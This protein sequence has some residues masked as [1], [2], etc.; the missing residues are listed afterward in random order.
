MPFAALESC[1]G[2]TILETFKLLVAWVLW[3]SRGDTLGK[4]ATSLL[5]PLLS[6]LLGDIWKQRVNVYCTEQ[7]LKRACPL[8]M[9]IFN[10]RYIIKNFFNVSF[11]E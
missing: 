8:S 6:D 11:S 9:V 4:V 3:E 10:D 2:D 7:L 5:L 1:L